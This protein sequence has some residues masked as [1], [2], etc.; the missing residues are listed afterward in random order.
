MWLCDFFYIISA[1]NQTGL[2]SFNRL[3]LYA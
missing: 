2:H 3:I 1:Q